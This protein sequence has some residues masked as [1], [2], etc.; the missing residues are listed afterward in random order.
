MSTINQAT[1]SS[2]NLKLAI[3]ID[4]PPSQSF[5]LQHVKQWSI[6]SQLTKKEVLNSQ[7]ALQQ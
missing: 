5:E 7:L 4:N 3:Q 2:V 6:Y 1:L